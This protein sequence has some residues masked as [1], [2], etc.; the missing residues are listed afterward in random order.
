MRIAMLRGIW[1][2]FDVS[3]A[4]PY[5]VHALPGVDGDAIG[6][7]TIHENAPFRIYSA[8]DGTVVYSTPKFDK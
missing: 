7:L 8:V 2:S 6:Q 4:F 3:L 5:E 1:S